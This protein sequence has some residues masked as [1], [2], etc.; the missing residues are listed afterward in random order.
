MCILLPY[1]TLMVLFWT[2]YVQ[3]R[4]KVVSSGVLSQWQALFFWIMFKILQHVSL[5]SSL[6]VLCKFIWLGRCWAKG[7][8][9]HR[10][11]IWEEI[12]LGS[13]SSLSQRK[14]LQHG[15][16]LVSQLPTVKP[17]VTTGYCTSFIDLFSA[18]FQVELSP[19]YFTQYD[20]YYVL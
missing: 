1:S 2:F 12:S 16:K 4:D 18:C 17:T 13:L 11:F 5:F 15:H 6:K 14:M 10:A 19:W 9:W 7:I 20:N 3:I 8:V